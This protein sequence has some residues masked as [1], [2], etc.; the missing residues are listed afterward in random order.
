MSLYF[1]SLRSSSSGNCLLVRTERTRVLIDCGLGSM[2]R[3]RQILTQNLGD[4]MDVDAVVVS[5]MHTDHIG[6]YSLRVMENLGIEVRVHESCL[7]QLKHKHFNGRGLTT[8]KLKPFADGGFKIGDLHFQPFEVPHNPWYRTYGFVVKHKRTKIVIATDFNYWDGLLEYFVDSDF[9]FVECNHDL[10]LLALY[11]NP[12][13]QF[14]MPNP[15]TGEL[16]CTVRQCSKTLPQAVMLGHLSE[17]RNRSEIALKEVKSS[18]ESRG[19]D[20]DFT[21]LVAPRLQA[22]EM[23]EVNHPTRTVVAMQKLS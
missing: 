11:Y 2:K 17:I 9:I 10:E 8:L 3:T 23:I 1:R 6:Y 4:Q 12:N 5:H 22:S 13:S 20:L 18:F 7:P 15:D 21:L 19:M 14:H 16:L